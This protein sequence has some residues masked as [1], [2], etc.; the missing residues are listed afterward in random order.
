MGRNCLCFLGR[1]HVSC[2]CPTKRVQVGG[3]RR[4]DRQADS[5]RRRGSHRN[6]LSTIPPEPAVPLPAVR[7]IRGLL[8]ASG[9][10]SFLSGRCVPAFCICVSDFRRHVLTALRSIMRRLCLVTP[11]RACIALAVVLS[12]CDPVQEVRELFDGA[13]PRESYV[14]RLESAGLGGSAARRA[15]CVPLPVPLGRGADS[16]RAMA[17]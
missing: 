4:T 12:A 1:N 5:D 6:G 3:E 9:A 11:A 8:A 13:T 17:R 14:Q 2:R 7:S 16:G 10:P 15:A